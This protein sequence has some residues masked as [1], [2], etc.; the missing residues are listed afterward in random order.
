MALPLAS[1]L[2]LEACAVGPD[3]VSPTPV[4]RDA[5]IAPADTTPVDGLWW[6]RLNDPVLSELVEAAIA[7]NKDLEEAG[8]R[9]R[10]ARANRDAVGGRAYPQARLAAAVTENQTSRN[11]ALPVGN[12]PGFDPRFPIH[13]VG[14]DASWEIDIWGAAQRAMEGADARLGAAEEARRGVLL[15]VLA[16]VVRAYVDL[17]LAQA[18]R[19]SVIADARAQ[20]EVARIVED[21]HRV[22][23]ASRL[24]VTRAQGQARSTAAAIP[25]LDADAAAAAYRLAL[26]SGRPPE[27]LADRLGQP[28]PLPTADLDVAVGLRSDLLR[29][30]PDI[31]QA[32]R[33]L[34]AATA[35]IGVATADLFPRITLMGGIGQ[36]ARSSGDLFSNDSL[37]FQAGPA[38]HWPI[39]SGGAIRARIRA[40]DARAEGSAARYERAVLTALADSETAINRFDA[41]RR[42]RAERDR[43]RAD[44]GETVGL[45]RRRYLAGEDDLTVLL[46]AQSALSV[47]DRSSI[48]AQAAELQQLA[49]LY[50]ALG[51]GWE[52]VETRAG[53]F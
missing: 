42:T 35:D 48:Q 9:L 43:I 6:R 53:G 44:A 19:E 10:E 31:R 47:A 17:R 5:W 38:L 28:A 26:L 25:G 23:L 29:R 11:G 22:G 20:T 3:Y 18:L 32:E 30:R 40:A 49:A 15:Q 33:D 45:A 24:D 51:G 27:A 39:F 16:E 37:R 50:K 36:Q 7:G 14:F 2:L 1:I 46:L 52:A 21:R 41:A 8:A 12:N 34:E 4:I 13:D